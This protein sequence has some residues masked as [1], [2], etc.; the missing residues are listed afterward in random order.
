MLLGDL[1]MLPSD[2]VLVQEKLQ[3]RS[4]D[5]ELVIQK[6]ETI[7]WKE[8]IGRDDIRCV[9]ELEWMYHQVQSVKIQIVLCWEDKS[10]RKYVEMYAKE[11]R[12]GEQ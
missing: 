6:Q 9:I 10:F 4:Y 12:D 5:Y 8:W 7:Q 3:I 1:M 11:R 2:M